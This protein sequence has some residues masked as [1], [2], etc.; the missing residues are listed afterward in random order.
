M[1]KSLGVGGVVGLGE[2]IFRPFIFENSHFFCPLRPILGWGGS[3]YPAPCRIR[4]SLSLSLVNP[5][6]HGLFSGFFVLPQAFEDMR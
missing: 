2:G 4:L 1:M 5:I 6:L 3:F